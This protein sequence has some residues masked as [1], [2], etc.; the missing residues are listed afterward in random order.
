[1]RLAAVAQPVEYRDAI[2]AADHDFAV[3]QARKEIDIRTFSYHVAD[4]D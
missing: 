4:S 3:D 2:F 1:L